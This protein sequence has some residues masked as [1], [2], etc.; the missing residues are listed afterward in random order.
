MQAL[1]GRGSSLWAQTR[2]SI[3]EMNGISIPTTVVVVLLAASLTT[4][5]QPPNVSVTLDDSGGFKVML[6]G[7]EWLRSGPVGI[8][9][10]GQWWAS[11][12]KDKYL[13]KVEKHLTDKGEDVFGSFDSD[14]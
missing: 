12:S 2:T 8:R 13:L 11:D 9:D 5:L 6:S 14:V 10:G 4:A 1:A 7:V 3:E